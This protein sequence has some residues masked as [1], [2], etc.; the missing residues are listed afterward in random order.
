MSIDKG[1]Y[2]PMYAIGMIHAAYDAMMPPG[3]RQHYHQPY[4][5]LWTYRRGFAR[6]GRLARGL[7]P[8]PRAAILRQHDFKSGRM[9]WCWMTHAP[10]ARSVSP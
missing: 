3:K 1:N 7:P 4:A 10:V 8:I 2:S 9:C 5:H 6:A